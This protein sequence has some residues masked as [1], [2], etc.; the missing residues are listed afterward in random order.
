MLTIRKA[1]AAVL[2]VTIA[3]ILTHR[4]T[5][6]YVSHKDVTP[7]ML[8]DLRTNAGATGKSL[9]VLFG[10]DWCSDCAEL[11]TSLKQ[12]A[13]RSYL[14]RNYVIVKVDVGEFDR[15]LAVAKSLGIE[16][17]QGIPTAV[18]FPSNGTS[19]TIRRGTAPILAYLK[20]AARE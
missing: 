18:F 9:M 10:A 16:V 15:N 7:A 14:N 20:E 8:Q 19:Q 11:S 17:S 12:D 5:P 4:V 1:G 13:F 2:V 3:V 6:P